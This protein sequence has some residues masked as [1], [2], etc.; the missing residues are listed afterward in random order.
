MP[1]PVKGPFVMAY[2]S[3]GEAP[4]PDGLHRG[5]V[6]ALRA[7]AQEGKP[8]SDKITRRDPKEAVTRIQKRY[9]ESMDIL[10]GVSDVPK[11]EN[12]KCPRCGA[13]GGFGCYE[14][15]PYETCGACGGAVYAGDECCPSC[16]PESNRTKQET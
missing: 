16:S 1:P 14:C 9:H 5:W 10:S 15:T 4:H 3:S 6:A 11:V 12:E 7:L 2:I 8:R 13:H